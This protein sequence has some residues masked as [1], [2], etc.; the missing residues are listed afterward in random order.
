METILSTQ[1][2]EYR[3]CVRANLE[4]AG[5]LGYRNPIA[6]PLATLVELWSAAEF[7][8]RLSNDAL[9]GLSGAHGRV[10]WEL[11]FRGATR[12]GILARAIG[13]GAPSITKAAAQLS[14]RGFVELIPDPADARAILLRLTGEGRRVTRELYRVGDDLI[15]QLTA[16]WTE[17]DANHAARLLTRLVTAA[18]QLGDQ[19]SR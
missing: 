15:S 9:Q 11:G 6:L 2:A 8:S 10:L 17:A 7:R 14:D 16:D 19:E 4:D 1:Y 18:R 5:D 3:G 13:V 12:P